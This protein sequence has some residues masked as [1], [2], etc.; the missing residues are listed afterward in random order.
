MDTKKHGI[1]VLERHTKLFT[2]SLGHMIFNYYQIEDQQRKQEI[3]FEILSFVQNSL[4]TD[5]RDNVVLDSY[6]KNKIKQKKQELDN[7]ESI[8]KELLNKIPESEHSIINKIF[9]QHLISFIDE[10][11]QIEKSLSKQE[12]YPLNQPV[13]KIS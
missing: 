7:V 12:E 5:P 8:R 6:L 11:I 13:D 3:Y 2:S 4:I 1:T 9:N 10:I